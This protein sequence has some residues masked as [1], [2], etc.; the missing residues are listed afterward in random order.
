MMLLRAVSALRR[1]GFRHL[2]GLCCPLGETRGLLRLRGPDA[3][4]FLQGLITND[5]QQLG[6]GALYSHLL[7]V[8]GRSLYDV[9]LYRLST[10]QN[11]QHDILLECDLSAVESVQKHLSVYNFRRKLTISRCP[12][13]SVWAVISVSQEQ[14]AK[15]PELPPAVMLT[16]DPRV[17]VMGWRLVAQCGENPKNLL[18]ETHIGNYSNYCKHR[19]EQGVPEGV[20]DILPGV[21]LPLESN[22][23]YMNGISFSK[24]CYLGQELTARTHHT[25]IIRKRLLP[26]RLSSPLPPDNKGADIATSTGKSA[27]KYRAG[28]GHTGLALLRLAHIDEELHIKLANG[29]SVTVETSQPE[30]WPKPSSN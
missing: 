7:N 20:K 22:L 9:I 6:E 24:G 16:P 12:E 10:G 29:Q 13:L 18:P 26:I 19:Y 15:I 25:G 14:E 17:D 8:Q 30:W 5:V 28:F 23:V 4:P 11:E 21:A 3:A 27:G 1:V 2:S